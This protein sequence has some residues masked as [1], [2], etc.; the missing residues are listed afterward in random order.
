[1]TNNIFHVRKIYIL[2]GRV[3]NMAAILELEDMVSLACLAIAIIAAQ[4]VFLA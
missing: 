3:C 2:E 1:M 4:F